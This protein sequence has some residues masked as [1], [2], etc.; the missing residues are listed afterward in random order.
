ML[1]NIMETNY[2]FEGLHSFCYDLYQL[3]N[4]E[5]KIEQ[6]EPDEL[7]FPVITVFR[8]NPTFQVQTGNAFLSHNLEVLAEGNYLNKDRRG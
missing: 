4:K 6:M 3:L 8:R 7:V 5:V 1:V 2:G